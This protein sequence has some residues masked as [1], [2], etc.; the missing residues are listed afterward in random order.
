MKEISTRGLFPEAKRSSKIYLVITKILPF[1]SSF[2]VLSLRPI[3][4]C[5]HAFFAINRSTRCSH[6][7]TVNSSANILM[8]KV[9]Q[10]RTRSYVP[11]YSKGIIE[12]DNNKCSSTIPQISL[13]NLPTRIGRLAVSQTR[14]QVSLTNQ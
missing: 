4:G 6:D 10:S 9:D 13:I 5:G 2:L 3:I 11:C 8:S 14:G 7:P 1:L 12:L